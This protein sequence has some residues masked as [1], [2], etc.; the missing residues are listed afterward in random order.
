MRFGYSLL[1]VS[2]LQLLC[3]AAHGADWGRGGHSK[4]SYEVATTS[5]YGH[6]IPSDVAKVI[7]LGSVAPDF[8]EFDN[9]S[10]HAQTDDPR[11]A[12][13]HVLG[14]RDY[15]ELQRQAYDRGNTWHSLYFR[16]ATRAMS[17]GHRERAAFLLGYALH[18]T[19]DF[20]THRGMPNILH[21]GLS[22][23]GSNPDQDK[24]RLAIARSLASLDI[25]RFRDAIGEKN[26]R[27]FTG[28]SADGVV[29]EPLLDLSR[30]LQTWNPTLGS[31]REKAPDNATSEQ[32]NQQVDQSIGLIGGLSE[33]R[34]PG[35]RE[36]I[37]EKRQYYERAMWGMLSRQD[38]MLE[39]LD[40]TRLG[41]SW[42]MLGVRAPM[43]KNNAGLAIYLTKA[44]HFGMPV[45]AESCSSPDNASPREKF[46]LTLQYCRLD[47]EER[48]RLGH[49]IWEQAYLGGD[50]ELSR[51]WRDKLQNSVDRI[52]GL[53]VSSLR[54]FRRQYQEALQR[55]RQEALDKQR[56][57]R[58][59]KRLPDARPPTKSAFRKP[60]PGKSPRP[61][62]SDGRSRPPAGNE[63]NDDPKGS[64][65]GRDC[66]PRW[67]TTTV[68]EPYTEWVRVPRRVGF[69]SDGTPIIEYY[70]E[71]RTRHR[72]VKE[73]TYI[74]C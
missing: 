31:L 51:R 69:E 20:A 19:E 30:D 61:T 37:E 62:R 53:D 34:F 66:N 43:P 14:R 71:P 23:E 22:H 28:R 29:P 44:V 11:D 52:R 40:V 27:L 4:I 33:Y 49:L 63:S 41:F 48:D 60:K 55:L 8:F 50:L 17:L 38:A 26:W 5:G 10:A 25:E 72:P 58:G 67:E 18:Y 2:L 13:G 36:S 21:A 6:G 74:P 46:S 12:S 54:K 64:N 3:V 59:A 15:E 35:L 39:L 47:A 73:Q 9:P 57:K 1:L 68:M 42:E 32:V 56:R 7:A 45:S 65:S 16:A 70:D 24:D